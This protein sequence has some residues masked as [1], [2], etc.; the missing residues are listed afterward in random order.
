VEEF[1]MKVL[2]EVGKKEGLENQASLVDDAIACLE[3]G[4]SI[5]LLEAAELVN[6]ET[7]EDV[8]GVI[9]AVGIE[10]VMFE[11]PGPWIEGVSLFHIHKMRREMIGRYGSE[12][13]LGNVDPGELIAVEAFRRGLGVNAGNSEK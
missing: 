11:L 1:G 12:V 10:K 4:S 9:A 6:P 2:G 3:A 5:I 8:E 7:A 13:N